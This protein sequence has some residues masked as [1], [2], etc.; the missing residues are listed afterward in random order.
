MD[1]YGLC[2]DCQN[3]KHT[4]GFFDPISGFGEP[5]LDYCIIDTDPWLKECIRHDEYLEIKK[6]EERDD[7][8]DE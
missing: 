5:P 1:S 7:I 6:S 4:R 3:C 8:I 2:S